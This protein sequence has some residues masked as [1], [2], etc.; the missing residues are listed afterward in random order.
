MDQVD[1]I[2]SFL[3]SYIQKIDNWALCDSFV[4]HLKIVS[5]YPDLFLEKIKQ[6]IKSKNEYEVRVGFV[7]L[8]NYYIDDKNLDQ[9]F[10]LCNQ[11]SLNTYYVKM[12]KAWLISQCFIQYKEKTLSFLKTNHLDS[13]TQ[14]RAISKIRDSYRVSKEDKDRVLKYKK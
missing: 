8:L 14:N 13:F 11:D 10:N 1:E 3:D 4:T 9:I 5:N 7:L 6:Y 2:L 12:A